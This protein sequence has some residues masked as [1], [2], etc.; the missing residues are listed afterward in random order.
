M[1]GAVPRCFSVKPVT[2][3]QLCCRLRL[4]RE[5]FFSVTSNVSEEYREGF[6]DTNKK[7][8]YKICQETVRRI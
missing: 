5:F 6:S 7:T 3:P 8:N 2:M 4:V 1:W